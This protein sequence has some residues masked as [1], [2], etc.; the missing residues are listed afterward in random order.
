E[1]VSGPLARQLFSEAGFTDVEVTVIPDEQDIIEETIIA[2][3]RKG[4]RC[5]VTSGGTGVGPRDVTVEAT[6]A[7]AETE[8]PGITEEIRRI[9]SVHTPTAMLSRARCVT[10]RV[11]GFPPA[12]VMNSPGSPGG[13]EDT[14]AVLL[15]VL[16]HLLAQLDGATGH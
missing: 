8:I 10:V 9:G 14:L 12:V 11:A 3:V 15:P 5:V 6:L 13:V 16:E 7:L 1:D 2:T 4:A